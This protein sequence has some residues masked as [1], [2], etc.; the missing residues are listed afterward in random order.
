[1]KNCEVK[2]QQVIVDVCQFD[3]VVLVVPLLFEQ[4]TQGFVIHNACEMSVEQIILEVRNTK[5]QWSQD[6][7]QWVGHRLCLL[8]SQE[9]RPQSG[10]ENVSSV[11]A[12]DHNSRRF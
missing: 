5:C 10:T 4:I 11:R 2:F 6:V 9:S 7:C 12:A 3:V 1:M 8:N